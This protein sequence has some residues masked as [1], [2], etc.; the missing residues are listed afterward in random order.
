[1]RYHMYPMA[2]PWEPKFMIVSLT[3]QDLNSFTE[4]ERDFIL[5]SSL[6]ANDLRFFASLL[7]RSPRDSIENTI[8]SMQN[9]RLMWVIR[10]MSASVYEAIETIGEFC[11]K[12]PTIDNLIKSQYLHLSKDICKNNK[13]YKLAK[14]FRNFSSHHFSINQLSKHLKRFADLEERRIFANAQLGNTINEITEKIF[15][16]P[17]ILDHDNSGE[18]FFLNW[19]D[20]MGKFIFD[21]CDK[22]TKTLIDLRFPGKVHPMKEFE[23]GNEAQ[24]IDQ[25][26]PLFSVVKID[27]GVWYS[28]DGSPAKQPLV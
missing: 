8:L 26:W 16:I 14:K 11:Q 23:F 2:R 21:F 20:D 10:K 17:N 24:E 18:L 3:T 9:V 6:I 13:S 27:G 22:A 7:I 15:T 12:I 28:E 4:A 19:C 25:R 5:A 1:M